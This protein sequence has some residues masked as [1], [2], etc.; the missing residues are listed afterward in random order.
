VLKAGIF[1]DI[2]NI[3]RSGGYGIRYRAVKALVEAQGAVV[4]RANAY[5]AIDS[6][7]ECADSE[8]GARKEDYRDWVRREGFHLV[9]KE[10]QRYFDYEGREIIKGNADL[11]LAVD[12]LLQADN[13]DYILLGSGD[14]DFV[15]LV[16]A[17]QNRGKRVD[18]LSFSNTNTTL[19]QE[20][21][22][23]F[24]G[25]LVPDIL[26]SEKGRYRGI[27]HAANEEQ[28]YGFLTLQVNHAQV[29]NDIFLHINDFRMP[30]GTKPA[31]DEFASL[32]QQC[33][34]EFNLIT[35]EDGRAKA[36]NACEYAPESV[37][38]G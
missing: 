24:N 30:D 37:R 35:D 6:G 21:D 7:R 9:L 3:S 23:H 25:Y 20:V 2:E 4:L 33:I 38:P 8:Y 14:V 10:V 28:A 19:R 13:L 12:A 36:V 11:D 31:N 22:F 26:P 17:L 5:M 1:L 32:R 29:R 27:M 16:R 18:L 15:R 34:I